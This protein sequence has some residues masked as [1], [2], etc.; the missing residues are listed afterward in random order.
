MPREALL[1]LL[2]RR[3][4]HWYLRWVQ[5]LSKHSVVEWAIGT[6]V[7][8]LRKLAKLRSFLHKKQSVPV[9]GANTWFKRLCICTEREIRE[10]T[11]NCGRALPTHTSMKYYTCTGWHVFHLRS[12]TEFHVGVECRFFAFFGIGLGIAHLHYVI[13][14]C[15]AAFL[16]QEREAA[17]P[18]RRTGV[19]TD[20]ETHVNKFS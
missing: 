11:G 14:A 18:R 4:D 17:L 7:R 15:A 8:T 19:G 2:G 9:L 12:S 1:P 3:D 16:P 20:G 5:H 6:C 13:T 10:M